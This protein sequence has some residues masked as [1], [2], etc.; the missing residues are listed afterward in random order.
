MYIYLIL[1]LNK[2]YQYL[3]GI[4]MIFYV[5][6]LNKMELFY[7]VGQKIMKLKYGIQK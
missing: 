7:I 6:Y 5:Y 2:N 1:H 4:K 3:K